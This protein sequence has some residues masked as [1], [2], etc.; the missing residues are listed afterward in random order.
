LRANLVAR[1]EDWFR[2]NHHRQGPAAPQD[3]LQAGPFGL[4]GEPATAKKLGL[5]ATLRAVGRARK[6][7]A[8]KTEDMGPLFGFG[9]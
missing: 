9:E 3:F 8:D 6:K 1:G 5:K 7:Y 4:G 2:S